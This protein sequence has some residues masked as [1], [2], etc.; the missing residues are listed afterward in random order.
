MIRYFY[1]WIFALVIGLLSCKDKG[2]KTVVKEASEVS[3]SKDSSFTNDSIDIDAASAKADDYYENFPDTIDSLI[4]C[5]AAIRE[6]NITITFSKDSTF[7]FYDYN[8][9]L[10]EQELLTGRFEL[11]GTVLT[12]FYSDSRSK[13]SLSKQTHKVITSTG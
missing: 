5:W 7:E 13:G 1:V 8:S 2:D 11:E 3:S 9:K 10:K 6:G 4:G 12:L